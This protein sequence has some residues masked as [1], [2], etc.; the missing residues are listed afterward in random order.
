[1]NHEPVGAD[2]VQLVRLWLLGNKDHAV[3]CLDPDGL[4]TAWLGGAEEMLGYASGEVLGQPLTA[5][6]TLEDQRKGL[7][8]YE[9]VVAGADSR[10]EDDRWHVRKDGTRIWV[11]GTVSPV[12]DENG[13]LLG[14]VKIM[15][16]R[17]DLRGQI[18]QLDVSVATL[19]ESRERTHQFL[20]TLGHEMRNPLGPLST[21]VR[22]I[23]RLDH[24]PKIDGALQIMS[25][26]LAALTRL[27]D[28]LMDVARMERG[29]VELSVRTVDLRRLIADAVAG[30][31]EASAAKG[32]TMEALLPSS[33]LNV[34]IDEA[35][36]QRLV[37]NLL[38]NA[39]KYTPAG[40]SIWIKAV[41][42]G[43]DTVL[44][45]EDTGI[46]IAPEVLPRIFELFT[47]ART[48][49][50]M[51]PGGLGVGLAMV[52]EIAEIHGGSVQARSAGIGKG[53][54]FTVRLPVRRV[55]RE[56]EFEAG[57]Y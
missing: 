31:E 24:D 13:D 56:T 26:Q 47:Q 17:T 14:F 30:L 53:A 23:E 44:R 2:V 57:R 49:A 36:F 51:S 46:G 10:S 7:D 5:I 16:D 19:R 25:R 3:I 8:R 12:R 15:R 27:A 52:R 35:R 29:K 37:L 55:P 11:T 38:G 9:L 18:E 43:E 34:D 20:R 4:V 32:L 40:G 45:V 39:I 33:A 1:M 6:F 54:E 48:A 41:H 21:A 28:D 42:E 22:I 50:D